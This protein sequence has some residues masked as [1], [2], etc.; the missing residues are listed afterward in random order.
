MSE[1]DSNL[2][3]KQ[4]EKL[5]SKAKE[6]GYSNIAFFIDDLD[7]LLRS[8][9]LLKQKD[10]KYFEL[11]NLITL[12]INKDISLGM[13][14]RMLSMVSKYSERNEELETENAS[15]KQSN[16]TMQSK[17]QTAETQVKELQKQIKEL[18]A[19]ARSDAKIKEES[20]KLSEEN[21]YLKITNKSLT[22]DFKKTKEKLEKKLDEANDLELENT[23]LELR[24]KDLQR[25]LKEVDLELTE[26][27]KK[28][29]GRDETRKKIEDLIEELDELY[30]TTDDPFKREFI[31]FMGVELS[32]IADNR[33][34]TKQ[35]ILNQIA[36]HARE[37]EK[38]FEPRMAA[39]Q[40]TTIVRQPTRVKTPIEPTPV[41]V[42]PIK[43]EIKE[44]IPEPV[45]RQPVK[46]EPVAE[47]VE[48]IDENEVG[49]RYVKPS[50]F[51]KGKSIHSGEAKE[52]APKVEEKEEV[53]AVTAPVEEEEEE[54]SIPKPKPVSI[55]KKKK[56]RGKAE[57]RDRT[58]SSDLVKVFDVFIK[59]LEAITD[60]SSF[61]D[62]CD[63][64][65]EELYEHVG[66]PGM[67]KVYKI[68]SGGVKRKQM[69][70]DLIKK[71]Q[72]QLPEM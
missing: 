70:I 34:I 2:S 53:V 24:M 71:W 27:K 7:M 48:D 40:P 30:T 14:P 33:N 9:N 12:L 49:D 8:A 69:L 57:P 43:E 47:L 55:T 20:I 60:N 28:I 32:E 29:K 67:T 15:M 37:I 59:Y 56:K 50:E 42:E 61:N 36:I 54:I 45:K 6:M 62:L 18:S 31:A 41:K 51:L 66:S 58:P 65:I 68:K 22:D 39:I 46:E 13:A 3:Q 25:E 4:L 63:K 11:E 16:I 72:V 21:K 17:Y 1:G 38:I 10:M 19:G 26:E 52:E 35:K 23:Q 44:V 64:L 5:I